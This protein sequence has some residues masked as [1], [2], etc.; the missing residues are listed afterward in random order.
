MYIFLSILKNFNSILAIAIVVYSLFLALTYSY[1]FKK[2]K[3]YIFR[4]LCSIPFLSALVHFCIC[5]IRGYRGLYFTF[6]MFSYLY[7]ETVMPMI[8][9]FFCKEGIVRKITS[10]VLSF[11]CFAAAVIFILNET[12]FSP[13]HNYSRKDWSASFTSAVSAMRKEYALSSWKEIDYDHLVDTYLPQIEE[14][15][16]NHDEVMYATIMTEFAYHFYDGHV[17]AVPNSPELIDGVRENLAGNDYGF[18]MIQLDS[19][20]FIAIRVDKASAAYSCGIHDGSQIV[21]WDGEDVSAAASEV[22]CI[23]PG[24]S[25]PAKENE[26]VFRPVFLAGKGGESVDVEYVNEEGYLNTVT[27]HS[28]GNYADR[29]MIVLRDL[30]DGDLPT[31]NNYTCMIDDNCGYLQLS[32]ESY[33]SIQDNIA[34]LRRGYYPSLTAYYNNLLTD[35][36]EQGMKHL[37]IDLR[38]NGGGY[39]CVAGAL[40][41]L[42]TSDKMHSVSFGYEDEDGYHITESEYIY[43]D[44][45]WK[46]L[47]VYVLVNQKCMSA[48][49]GAAKFLSECAN[50]TLIGVTASNGVNQNNGG[51]IF[52]SDNIV[53]FAYPHYMSLDANAYPLIDTDASR[54]NRVPLDV[55]IPMTKELA[56]NIFSDSQID[57]ELE[58]VMDYIS[59][60]N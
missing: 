6:M 37:I 56:L 2:N 42:F 11:A 26:D 59:S 43:P 49:D 5:G 40:V 31:R 8:G 60:S 46:D 12:S 20:E 9:V 7:I 18:S 22:E 39:D 3:K 14:A 15:Q 44:G 38:N 29:L 48:G 52:M 51:Y 47:P 41:S 32:A 21:S 1:F 58:Y 16:R 36:Y 10:A 34:V 27:L 13:V 45:R 35:L 53:V 30:L 24:F 25:F 55:K 57:Y 33:N 19:G 17:Y 50:V 4:I 54:A 23:Y 28:Q